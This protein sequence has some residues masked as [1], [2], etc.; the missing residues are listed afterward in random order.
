MAQMDHY[1]RAGDPIRFDG[2]HAEFHA[3]FVARGG[4]RLTTAVAQL[5]DHAVRYRLA[6]GAEHPTGYGDRRAEHRAMIEAAAAGDRDATVERMV[7]HYAYTAAGVI[8]ELDPEHEP[9]V[10]ISAVTAVAPGVLDSPPVK[11]LRERT[12]A[13]ARKR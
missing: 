13:P 5:F 11:Q 6:Y 12:A 1:T 2:P 3:R 7:E 10:L 8:S 4:A 9:A